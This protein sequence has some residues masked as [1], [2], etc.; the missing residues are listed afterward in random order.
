MLDIKEA[1]KYIGRNYDLFLKNFNDADDSFD[2]DDLKTEL[3][4][5][6]DYKI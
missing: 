2:D 3:S 1:I 6:G 4:K 5:Q